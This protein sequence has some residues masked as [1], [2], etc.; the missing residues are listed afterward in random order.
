MEILMAADIWDSSSERQVFINRHIKF[1]HRAVYEISTPEQISLLPSEHF[2]IIGTKSKAHIQIRFY[3]I[4][5]SNDI[6]H[7][8]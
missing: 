5:M 2:C 8:K 6:N 3:D 7:R 1:K 4:N